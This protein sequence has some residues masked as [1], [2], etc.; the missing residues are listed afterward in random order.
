[1]VFG[2][3][4]FL[5]ASLPAPTRARPLAPRTVGQSS[6]SSL[7]CLCPR[8]PSYICAFPRC[9]LGCAVPDLLR[10]RGS[11]VCLRGAP[12][13]SCGAQFSDSLVTADGGLPGDHRRPGRFRRGHVSLAVG[14]LVSCRTV[15]LGRAASGSF[16]LTL[17][18]LIAG[19]DRLP[20]SRQAAGVSQARSC[21]RQLTFCAVEHDQ[22]LPIGFVAE[23]QTEQS[24]SS[25]SP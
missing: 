22:C 24:R 8:A 12:P 21:A 6:R 4:R 17:V 15:R 2:S 3:C 9:R 14:Q 7:C 20:D 13:R 23:R 25:N 1:M 11:L 16:C 5:H 19:R 18:R 10:W